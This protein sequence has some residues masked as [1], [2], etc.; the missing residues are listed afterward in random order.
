MVDWGLL[1]KPPCYVAAVHNLRSVARCTGAMVGRLLGQGLP[2]ATLTCV[3]HSLGAHI[4]GIM[5][6]YLPF[7]ISRIIGETLLSLEITSNL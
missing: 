4:C 3:G 1:C 5:A 7:R 2:M 6:N